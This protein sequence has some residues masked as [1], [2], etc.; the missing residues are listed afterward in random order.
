MKTYL[1]FACSLSLAALAAQAQPS[2]E[3]VQRSSSPTGL[4]IRDAGAAVP[5]HPAVCAAG[6]TRAG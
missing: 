2:N 4:Q 6:G 3:V 1:A 5:T